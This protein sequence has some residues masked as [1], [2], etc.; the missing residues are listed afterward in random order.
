MF[1]S[2]FIKSFFVILLFSFLISIRKTFE[3][4]S[5]Q[6][7]YFTINIQ[8]SQIVYEMIFKEVNLNTGIII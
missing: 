2:S 4:S 5:T 6:T 1:F 8:S 3:M 7:G